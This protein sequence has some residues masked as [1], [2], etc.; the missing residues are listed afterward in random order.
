MSAQTG[1]YHETH[2]KY[3]TASYICAPLKRGFKA[4]SHELLWFNEIEFSDRSI[5]LCYLFRM[6]YGFQLSKLGNFEA[7]SEWYL[8][9]N[10][11]GHVTLYD[12]DIWQAFHFTCRHTFCS[13][14]FYLKSIESITWLTRRF[15]KQMS[16]CCLCVRWLDAVDLQLLSQRLNLL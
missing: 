4:L 7:S 16:K 1:T 2:K 5:H 12:N 3:W 8:W 14:I 13:R 10:K 15:N 9:A 11:L 6:F